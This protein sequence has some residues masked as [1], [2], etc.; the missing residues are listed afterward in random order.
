MIHR[1]LRAATLT[2]LVFVLYGASAALASEA[3][4]T[5]AAGPTQ[6]AH[7]ALLLPVQSKL[8]G[9]HARAL[10]NG[11]RAAAK[12]QG[13]EV[14]PVRDYAVSEDVC[15]VLEGYRTAV[16]AGAQVVVGPLTRDA[17]T[18]LA[19]GEPVP[20]PTLALNV[21]DNTGRVP[22]NLYMLSLQVETEARQA[23]QLAWREGRRNAV[24]ISGSSPVQRRMQSAFTS[25]FLQLGGKVTDVAYSADPATLSQIGRSSIALL[26]PEKPNPGQRDSN[27]RR[28]PEQRIIARSSEDM[29]FLAL[30]YSAARTARAYL[31]ATPIYATSS[32]HIGDPGPLAGYDLAGITF[33]DMPWMLEPN[34][35]AVMIYPRANPRST[36]DLERLYALGID[37]WRAAQLLLA[38][39]RDIRLDGVTGQLSPGPDGQIA[40]LLVAGRYVDGQPRLLETAS[41]EPA[42]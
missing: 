4:N 11:F 17:V 26:K 23:A 13:R 14:L 32:V 29:Y 25:E 27:D 24:I 19:F 2:G 31:G 10:R 21:A 28:K 22:D 36:A 16:A 41:R 7:I 3:G 38:G 20:V 12:V 6:S 42:R 15:N 37:A 1:L 40:R 34:H 33:V 35:A 39:A 8:F 9:Q 18:A 30:D 5:P